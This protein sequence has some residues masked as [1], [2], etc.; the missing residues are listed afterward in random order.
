M[1]YVAT[2]NIGGT[3][4]KIVQSLYGTCSTASST[5]NKVVTCSDFDS[6]E[7]GTVIV[8]K[9]DNAQSANVPHMNVNSTGNK[10]ILPSTWKVNYSGFVQ[11]FVYDGSHWCALD[12]MEDADTKTTTGSANSTDAKLFLIGG[13][14]QTT[15]LTT[16]SYSGVYAEYDSVTGKYNLESDKVNGYTLG[17]ACE[18]FVGT[19]ADGN[20]GLVTGNAVYDAIAAAIGQATGSMVY[21]GS[22]SSSASLKNVSQQAGYVYMADTAF[23]ITD[24]SSVVHAVE[25]GDMI[26]FNTTGTYTTDAALW[27]AIDMYQSNLD[28]LSD[29]DIDAAIAEAE[30]A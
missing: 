17:D 4:Y 24:G 15:Y 8:V 14:S 6:F 12:W 16:K 20:L 5:A 26:I 3:D 18:K 22:V 1:G 9:F 28:R 27:A 23:T 2:L 21:Q 29:T 10:Q 30:A 11:A 25:V 19:V 13:T 7:T